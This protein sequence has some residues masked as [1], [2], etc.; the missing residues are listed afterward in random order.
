[1]LSTPLL[2]LLPLLPIFLLQAT[3]TVPVASLL[4]YEQRRL[5]GAIFD[6]TKTNHHEESGLLKDG[7]SFSISTSFTV[8]DDVAVEGD[9]ITRR[10]QAMQHYREII[11]KGSMTFTF[12]P[13]RSP[14]P[15][16]PVDF[17]RLATNFCDDKCVGFQDI[18]P[19]QGLEGDVIIN[20]N[21]TDYDV[22]DYQI[23]LQC[24]EYFYDFNF[25]HNWTTFNYDLEKDESIVKQVRLGKERGGGL[26]LRDS[27]ISPT[28]VSNNLLARRFAPYRPSLCSSPP[29]AHRSTLSTSP[30]W[31]PR[32]AVVPP[33]SPPKVSAAST[34]T[35]TLLPRYRLFYN[36]TR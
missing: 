28:T 30:L 4:S 17:R 16:E 34:A 29:F 15:G 12:K 19:E 31:L 36:G 24:M 35:R 21:G 1:M 9:Q 25:I 33:S 11:K 20:V 3:A 32:V 22:G 27:S 6:P 8:H 26:E 10:G 18:I 5:V 14:S 7:S 2:L 23:C 13:P